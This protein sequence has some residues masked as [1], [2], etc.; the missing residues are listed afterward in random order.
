MHWHA[1]KTRFVI[2]ST[3]A[4]SLACFAAVDATFAED[5]PAKPVSFHRQLRPIFQRS[6]QGCHQPAK[7]G[8]K[9]VITSHEL[10]RSS[11]RGKEPIVVPGKPDESLLVTQISPE[12]NEPPEM[13]KDA[14]ALS[15]S[16]VE[17]VRRWIAE[18]AQDDTPASEKAA[19]YTLEN[20]PRYERPPVITAVDYAP[21]G[22]LLAVSGYHET[23]LLKPEGGALAARLVGASERIESVKFSPDGRRLAVTGGVPGQ[24]GEVQVWD[25]AERKLLLSVP[26][27]YDVVFGASWSPVDGKVL[28][29]GCADNSVRAIDPATGKELLFQGA[30]GDWVLGTT[31]SKDGSHL[32]SVSRDMSMKLIVVATQQFVDNISSITPGALKG[33]L[34]SVDRHPQKDEVVIGGSDGQPKIYRIFREKARQIGDDFNLIRAFDP[35]MP[36]RVFAVEFSRDATLV[37]AG[38]S[39]NRSGELRVYKVDDGKQVVALKLDTGVYDVAFSPDGA[40][41]AAGGFDGKLRLVEVATGKIVAE[42]VPVPLEL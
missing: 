21:D 4:L 39:Y 14:P 22:S 12:G 6:C 17:L 19:A 20:P 27:G 41:V 26:V 7:A 11:G 1:V 24:M 31:F 2:C 3:L 34:Q 18:G 28:A 8:G 9:F 29:F 30:H 37:A 10:L 42:V 32:I 36:G 35:P 13:P 33:G 16:D 23:L 5:A 25:V 40:R 38:S 15:A